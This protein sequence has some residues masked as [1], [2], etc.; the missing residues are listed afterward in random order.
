ML[1]GLLALLSA[2]TFGFNAVCVRRGVLT[3]SVLQ[4][5]AVT[6][7]IGIPVT[8]LL[9]LV[10]GQAGHIGD[11][12]LAPTLWLSAAGIVHFIWGRYYSYL[13]ME[14]V[15]ANL[16]APVQQF[17]LVI[18]LGLAMLILGETI[19]P[20]KAFGLLLVIVG[21]M[22]AL[23]RRKPEKSGGQQP[24]GGEK[25]EDEAPSKPPGF[26]PRYF[27]GY[28]YGFLSTF[29][30]G[31]SPILVALGLKG[32]SPGM[33]LAGVFISYLAATAVVCL[34]LL[35]PGKGR[36]AL[37]MGREP[38][39]W[40]VLSGIFVGISQALRYMALTV[41]P[42]TVV[43]PIQRLSTVFRIVFGWS[44]NRGHE[45]LNVWVIV[46][47]ATSLLGAIA[48]SIGTDIVIDNIP[49]PDSVVEMIRWE[50]P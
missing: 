32:L 15:G 4:A 42:V 29:G 39:K 44:I 9:V 7:P 49:M 40:F 1:G 30:Q 48:L 21:P 41:A 14:A 46:G 33:G 34:V 11:F 27:E 22:I 47:I 24:A 25:G 5:M 8:F 3:G 6:V 19:T 12:P 36:H 43:S 10:S 37:S 16:A 17:T 38:V 13:S 2:A 35:L 28:L 45:I 20:L 26:Q 50:W 18:S 23:H 31:S